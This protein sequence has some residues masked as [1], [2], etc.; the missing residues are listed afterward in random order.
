MN[1]T[2]IFYI[3]SAL[4]VLAHMASVI[5]KRKPEQ[6]SIGDWFADTQNRWYFAVTILA[7]GVFILVGPG[8]GADLGSNAVRMNAFAYAG[9]GA[10]VIRTA[11]LGPKRATER[12]AMKANPEEQG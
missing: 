11:I 5:Y 6:P 9:L 10:E 12:K 7:A 1:D 3:L 4:G 2:T 8:D